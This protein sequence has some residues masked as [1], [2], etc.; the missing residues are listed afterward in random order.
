MQA[1][2][3]N[4]CAQYLSQDSKSIIDF[5]VSDKQNRSTS[6]KQENKQKFNFH[7]LLTRLRVMR[8]AT[9][10]TQLHRQT[11]YSCL[12]KGGHPQ[13]VCSR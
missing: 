2:V 1:N 8:V 11:L 9:H 10:N 13:A 6:C 4:M 5:C 12:A 7:D 3:A